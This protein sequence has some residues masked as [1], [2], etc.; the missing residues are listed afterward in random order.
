MA[1]PF[2]ADKLETTGDPVPIAEQVDYISAIARGYFTASQNGVLVYSSGGGGANSQLTWFDRSGKPTGTLGAPGVLQWAALSPDGKTVA[3]D[4]L[5]STSGYYDIWLNDLAR[6][7]ASRFTFNS[8]SNQFPVWSA[9]GSH[10]A[11]YSTRNAP[12]EIYQKATAGSSADEVLS[13][14]APT[15]RADDWSRDGRYLFEET[16]NGGKTAGDI[17]VLPLFGD[18]KPFPY[19]QTEFNERSAKLSPD[20]QWLAYASDETK[21]YEI[22]VQ[23]FP[24][25]GGKWQ[26]SSNGG[27]L[28]IWSRDGKELF[29]I[30]ADQKLMAV[31]VKGGAKFEAGVPKL[32]FDTHLSGLNSGYD[33]SKDG[34]FL[35]PLAMEQATAPP[36]TVV[37]NWNAGMKRP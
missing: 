9:D 8:K 15:R 3:T 26:V 36:M 6:G 11:Y 25:P 1:Q 32:L 12:G 2:D 14:G 4:R 27:G 22:Y 13:K 34:R 20:G 30:G 29:F 28:P 10:I 24:N 31:E 23:T 5:D 33:V 17:W 35:I 21:R 37:I 7:T 18:R 19:L 16:P